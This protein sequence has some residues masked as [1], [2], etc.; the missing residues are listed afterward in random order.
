MKHFRGSIRKQ[1]FLGYI[2]TILITVILAGVSIIYLGLINKNYSSATRNRENQMATQEAITAHYKWLDDLNITIQTGAEFGGSLDYNKCSLGEWIA[3]SGSAVVEDTMIKD[4]LQ[5]IITPHQNIHNIAQEIITL[6]ASD[7]DAAFLRYTNEI[8]PQ[9]VSVIKGLNTITSEYK[10]VAG[11]ASQSLGVLI[12]MSL[13]ICM[14]LVVFGVA[15]AVHFGNTIS[16]RISNPIKAVADWSKQLSLGIE[17]VDF[18]EVDLSENEDNEISI[19][20]GSFKRMAS[21]IQNNADVIQR[22]SDGDM[23]AFVNIRSAEDRLGNNLYRMVQS[24]DMMFREILQIAGDVANGSEHIANASQAL[25]HDAS[26]Q[27]EA[28]YQLSATIDMAGELIAIN[29]QRTKEATVIS[30]SI[31]LE[32]DLSNEKMNHLVESV[33]EI[34]RASEEVAVVIKSIEDIAFQTNILAINAAIEAARAGQA[35]KGFAVVADE[36]RKLAMKSA[37]AADSSR[38]L[39]ENTIAK[40]QTGD[41][42]SNES[43]EAFKSISERIKEIV[44]AI[45]EIAE[46]SD[47]QMEGIRTIGEEIVNIA[48]TAKTSEESSQSSAASSSDMSHKADAL[49][50]WMSKFNLRDRD[51]GKA[52]IPKEKE[53]DSEYI[54]K[55]TEL[56]QKSMTTGTYGNGYIDPEA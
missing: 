45:S 48:N 27:A 4:A 33:E 1:I 2:I 25:A 54:R 38:A 34:R 5:S 26:V 20:V 12:K 43:L 3:A 50:S 28:V 9:V 32:S 40:T 46:C 37:A 35:G 39:I 14:I 47:A 7:K 15:L 44:E 24:N 41:K 30:E 11:E 31:K 51:R 19:M 56:Y 53:N 10:L 22:V 18:N 6:S 49:K 13:I 29:A 17:T 42:I 21:S 8:K 52:Y 16:K 23:T 55:A 36:V